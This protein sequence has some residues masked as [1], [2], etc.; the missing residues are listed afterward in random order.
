MTLLTPSSQFSLA[1]RNQPLFAGKDTV[2]GRD[3]EKFIPGKQ[4]VLATET[5]DPIT[6]LYRL[7]QKLVTIKEIAPHH[8]ETINKMK[9]ESQYESSGNIVDTDYVDKITYTEMDGT[10]KS[11]LYGDFYTNRGHGYSS[12]LDKRHFCIN[13]ETAN[14]YGGEQDNE[15]ILPHELDRVYTEKPVVIREFIPVEESLAK[16]VTNTNKTRQTIRDL[17]MQLDLLKGLFGD[18][19]AEIFQKLEALLKK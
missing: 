15:K 14:S 9:V 17:Q 16:E 6:N 11:L 1:K 12:S 4:M 2:S 5:L 7:D 3:S 19:A 8:G 10:E 18:K 13:I